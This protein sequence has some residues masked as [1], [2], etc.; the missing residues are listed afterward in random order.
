MEK[1]ELKIKKNSCCVTAFYSLFETLLVVIHVNTS[2]LDI[3][4]LAWIEL[5]IDN[6]FIIN[7]PG[8]S[9]KNKTKTNAIYL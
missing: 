9:Q 5:K 6:F 1:S 4:V 7:I 3:H 8:P 2:Y